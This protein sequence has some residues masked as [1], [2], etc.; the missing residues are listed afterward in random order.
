MEQVNINEFHQDLRN[1][2]KGTAAGA[3][4][5]DKS[6]N[7]LRAGRSI[8]VDKDG[9]IIAGN[10]SAEAAKKNGITDV[11][12]VKTDSTKLVAVKRTDVDIN[13]P[14]GRALAFADNRTAQVNLSW[15]EVQLKSVGAELEEFH[16]EDWGFQPLATA[17]DTA[18]DEEALKR[19]K[20]EFEERMRA[21]EIT[22]DDEEY[23]A[24][25]DKFQRK[26]TT[27][28]CYTPEVVYNAVADWVANTYGLQKSR[29]KRPFYPGG[30]YQKD[31]YSPDDIVVDNPP[32]SI[33]AEILT[34]YL[35]HHIRFFLFA[36]H[37]T[38]MS[39]SSKATVIGVGVSITYANGAEVNTSFLTNLEPHNVRLRS[40]PTLYAAVREANKLVT[41][42]KSM[43][44]YS[45]PDNIITMTLLAKLSRCAV[46]FVVHDDESINVSQLD[47]QRESGKTI[48]GKAY[49]CTDEVAARRRAA[50]AEAV[51]EEDQSI[52]WELSERELEEIAKLVH[53]AP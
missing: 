53:R 41:Q 9:N 28:D 47:S 2:N 50:E 14:R 34:W 27:D 31:S 5:L 18:E 33:T 44:S 32:F 10:K 4:L 20:E 39:S 52:V 36:P 13:S 49:L 40:A 11:I 46:D 42:K 7:D 48:F 43:P 45:Y 21:G 8:L 23:K 38:A 1:F 6:F 37:L 19:K 12:V 16:T 25:C 17:E 22:E 3:K 24:F 15:D 26:H 30:D 29:F 35:E 51:R